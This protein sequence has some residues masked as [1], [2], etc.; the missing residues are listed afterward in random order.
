[1]RVQ[2]EQ[3]EF[4]RIGDVLPRVM[5]LVQAAID[6]GQSYHVHREKLPDGR[7]RVS[8]AVFEAEEEE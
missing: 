6:S 7:G 8:V 1:M 3:I 5:R 2:S 4:E